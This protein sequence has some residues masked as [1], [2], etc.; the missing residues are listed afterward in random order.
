[1]VHVHQE[2]LLLSI[3]GTCRTSWQQLLPGVLLL[4]VLKT[5]MAFVCLLLCLCCCLCSGGSVAGCAQVAA[6][7]ALPAERAGGGLSGAAAAGGHVTLPGRLNHHTIVSYGIYRLP[8]A[9][10]CLCWQYKCPLT[11][12]L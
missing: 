5:R 12:C 2:L 7:G 10:F 8:S 11:C 3:A 6:A 9:V 1:M 4:M